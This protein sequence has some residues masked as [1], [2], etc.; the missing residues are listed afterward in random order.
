[1]KPT[2]RMACPLAAALVLAACSGG[3]GDIASTA[4]SITV[5]AGPGTGAPP[6]ESWSPQP[7]GGSTLNTGGAGS[8][9]SGA[10]TPGGR[11]PSRPAPSAGFGTADPAFSPDRLEAAVAAVDRALQLNAEVLDEATLRAMLPE[12]SGASGEVEFQPA[13]CRQIAVSESVAAVQGAALAGLTFGAP[14]Q[15]PVVLNVAA[16]G[17]ESVLDTLGFIDEAVLSDCAE[18]RMSRD[19][20]AVTVTNTRLDV[21]TAAEETLALDTRVSGAAGRSQLVVVSART[22]SVRLVVSVPAPRDPQA[23]AREAAMLIDAVLAEL[24]LAVL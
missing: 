19:G 7:D 8:G 1:M 5:P 10:E 9:D 16:Y 2:R 17:D 20:T 4:P 11:V 13:A 23:A 14:G 21:G 24:G 12:D 3:G 18:V 15:A 6:A 22:G